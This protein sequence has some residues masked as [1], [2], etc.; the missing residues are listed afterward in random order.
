MLESTESLNCVLGL[1]PLTVITW[2]E[3]EKVKSPI[4][5]LGKSVESFICWFHT[6]QKLQ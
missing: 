5:P 3:N 6:V 1:L 2:F 4:L